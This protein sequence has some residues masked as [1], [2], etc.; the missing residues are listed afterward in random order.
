MNGP[1]TLDDTFY[2]HA[3]LTLLHFLWQGLLLAAI[4]C[5][6]G[7]CL[8]NRSAATRYRVY[9]AAMIL[10]LACLPATLVLL[11]QREDASA[12]PLVLNQHAPLGPAESARLADTSLTAPDA[13]PP[14]ALSPASTE[15]IGSSISPNVASVQPHATAI[16]PNAATASSPTHQPN[17]AIPEATPPAPSAGPASTIEQITRWTLSV[18]LLGVS[19]MFTRTL[20][21]LSGTR[22]LRRDAQPLTDAAFLQAVRRRARQFNLRS[23]P[24]VAYCNRVAVPALVGL[25]RPMILLPTVLATGLTPE[26]LELV[27]VHEL[28]HIRRWDNAWLIVQRT[29][30]SILFFHPAVWYISRR[31]SIERELCCDEMVVATAARPSQYAESLLRVVELTALGP[32]PAGV[33]MTSPRDGSTF[34]VHR[35]MRILGEAKSSPVRL[36]RLWP[37]VLVTLLV[38]LAVSLVRVSTYDEPEIVAAESVQAEKPERKKGKTPSQPAL[39]ERE[40]RMAFSPPL[41]VLPEGVCIELVGVSEYPQTGASAWTADGES[42]SDVL[43]PN[44]DSEIP[45]IDVSPGKIARIFRFNILAPYSHELGLECTAEGLSHAEASTLKF[46]RRDDGEERTW[47]TVFLFSPEMKTADLVVKSTGIWTPLSMGYSEPNPTLVEGMDGAELRLER[48][49]N[50]LS[51]ESV[52]AVVTVPGGRTIEATAQPGNESER[53]TSVIFR[54]PGMSVEEIRGYRLEYRHE[55]SASFHNVSLQHG[56]RTDISVGVSPNSAYWASYAIMYCAPSLKTNP[57]LE[58]FLW[59]ERHTPGSYSTEYFAR[60]RSNR[61]RCE[62]VLRRAQ[63]IA[64]LRFHEGPTTPIAVR[65][66]ANDVPAPEKSLAR[67]I[68]HHELY[69]RHAEGLEESDPQW[70]NERKRLMSTITDPGDIGVGWFAEYFHPEGTSGSRMGPIE[71]GLLAELKPDQDEIFMRSRA[72]SL[73]Y[74]QRIRAQEGCVGMCHV[75]STGVFLPP[76]AL[77]VPLKAGD[78]LAILG[79]EIMPE[80]PKF[81][82]VNL[83]GAYPPTETPD[84]PIKDAITPSG[85]CLAPKGAPI[86]DAEVVLYHLNWSD[87]SQ[88][89]VERTRSNQQ[90]S[91]QF[92]QVPVTLERIDEYAVVATAGGRVTAFKRFP[93]RTTDGKHLELHM[94]EASE[95]RGQVFGPDGKPVQGAMVWAHRPLPQPVLG[96][97]C[98]TTDEDGTFLIDDVATG[99]RK[100][101]VTPEDSQDATRQIGFPLYCRHPEYGY[102]WKR[103]DTVPGE[104]T[105]RLEPAAVMEGRVVYADSDEPAARIRVGIQSTEEGDAEWT[106]TDEQG[107]YRFTC[108]RAEKYNLWTC[109]PDW[110]A[111]A[112]DSL[113]AVPGQ[114]RKAPDLRLIRGAVISGRFVHGATGKPLTLADFHAS[115]AGRVP[116]CLTA[117]GP[118]RPE[119]GAG[120]QVAYFRSDGSFE[121]RLPPGENTIRFS[122]PAP[123]TLADYPDG[124]DKTFSLAEGQH[125]RLDLWVEAD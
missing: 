98:A 125:L 20:L 45:Q 89:V 64:E 121:V 107:R 38:I 26:Q 113:E 60:L 82:R 80:P 84:K 71:R 61:D 85:H 46:S 101:V 114:T 37:S 103:Y 116:S 75:S 31:M 44:T 36:P 13:S 41:L 3:A 55:G 15:N 69:R 2:L 119:S 90:G 63:A 88:R 47:D 53:R 33:T 19:L 86:A 70:Q 79:V 122:P 1:V 109:S 12:T 74:L 105:L 68:A 59:A 57:G 123:W 73:R 76:K 115:F 24:V 97:Q 29:I 67:L 18:Y 35:L 43:R 112:I 8:Q 28:A 95:L 104:V 4:A 39:E 11:R 124:L 22:R 5:L 42:L 25:W 48:D 32:V 10:M 49:T 120:R 100:T 118:A 16:S 117:K 72:G 94:P 34:L 62:Y 81:A 30:E 96:L 92:A 106:V 65:F 27:V 99:T 56:H 14:L 91:F 87:R 40:F 110:T 54:F 17:S 58:Q 52:R 78:V 83:K 108:L 23:T 77:R 111:P 21:G 50:R 9:A 51:L 102:T 6:T 7:W 66:A 93:Y